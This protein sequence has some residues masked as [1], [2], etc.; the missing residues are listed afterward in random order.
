MELEDYTKFKLKRK[1]ELVPFLEGKDKIFVVACNKCFKEFETADEPDFGEFE[2]IAAEQGKTLAGFAKIDFVCN[3]TTTAKK[4][5][6][7][8]PAE[9][10]NVFVISCGLGIQTVADLVEK[11]VYAAADSISYRGRHG[12]ALTTTRCDAC[13]Q[14]YL[15]L[16]GGICP[17]VDCA[18]SLTNGQCGGAKNGK[19]EVD[20]TKDCAWQKIY[21]RLEKQ[22][23]LSELLD[24]P[25]QLRDYSKINFK[26]IND[27]VKSVREKRF[28]G[29]YG[30]IH[31]SERKEFTEHL[32]LVTFPEP[33]TVVI[34]M[35]QHAGAPAEPVVAAGDTV[36]VGQKIGEAKGAIS[37]NIHASVSGTVT[38]I[39]PRL[40]PIS[41]AN[42]MSVVIK[43]D[44]KNTLHESVQPAGSL[45]SL[46]PDE[47]V[48]IVREKGIVGMGGAGF[49]TAVKIKPPKPVDTVLLNGCECEPLLTA[50]HRVLVEYAD[51]VIFGLQALL[52]ASGAEKGIIAI[53]DNKP[54]A[55]EVLQAKTADINNIEVVIA[56]TKYPQGAEKMLIKRVLGRQVPSGGLPADVGAIVSNI[57]TVKAVS[58][59]IQK[60][61]PLIERVVTVT[62]ERM[63]KPGNFIV[64]I[65]TSVKEL[66]DYCG[67]VVG[68]DVTIKMGGPQMGFELKNLEVPVLKGS[69]GVIAVETVVTEPMPCI[70]CGRCAD[71]CP[72]ELRPLYFSKYAGTANWQGFK[73]Q[74]VMDCIEC[75][76]CETICS[77][78]IPL[79][80]MIKIGKQAIREGK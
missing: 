64:K 49:P 43:S 61:M 78:K 58:D 27:Y 53:E 4:L 55:I 21:H 54:D 36:K 18:K 25:T 56:K 63:K 50:D 80:R 39:E 26:L 75:K 1:E 6:S 51:D 14:C 22:G 65:G 12:M 15:N 67:G 45:D 35:S 72:M 2:K 20:K 76:C 10:E 28:E 17:I 71:V 69:N 38:A 37:S 52:K 5:Q 68:D 7:M 66:V 60:G 3:K 34:P 73:D 57:S 11:P 47:I 62:G 77:S 13:G 32:A 46:T 9:A 48:N 29:Y 79:V 31:P 24:Q 44:G 33:Q 30:G 59:A 70:K 19:C 40:H 8:L 41:G 16:T 23:R 42:V 74:S